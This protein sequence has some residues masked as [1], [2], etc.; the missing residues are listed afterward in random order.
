[1]SIPAENA[2]ARSKLYWLLGQLYQSGVTA[3]LLPILAA[4]DE[5]SAM[6]PKNQELSEFAA[7]HQQIFGFA[8][9]AHES[10]FLDSSGML[11][12]PVAESVASRYAQ[13][14][15]QTNLSPADC[16]Q[17]GAE[18]MAISFLCQA[19]AEA[20]IDGV[21]PQ[22][23]RMQQTQARFMEEHL[24]CWAVPC[25]WAIQREDD[26]FY[27]AAAE[28]TWDLINDHFTEISSGLAQ[29]FALPE[30]PDLLAD[31]KTSLRDI[32]EYLMTPCFSGHFISRTT[33]GRI[34]RELQL[35]RGFTDR[36]TMLV[37]LMQSA[38]Q[39]DGAIVL[40]DALITE[41]QAAQKHYQSVLSDATHFALQP[42]IERTTQTVNLLTT[43]KAT[44]QIQLAE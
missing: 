12:G 26:P 40:M 42:W 14:G 10:I 44:T 15:Y 3:E 6:L 43:I 11:G 22:A 9:F 27:N 17:V 7:S 38:A 1:M 31:D 25:L 35:P 24:L 2:Q 32:A 34:G 8:L 21:T 23:Q 28:I 16:D 5:L 20:W 36:T 4:I 41:F 19:E 33:I 37:N 39:Y 30:P 13:L 18:L 29:P